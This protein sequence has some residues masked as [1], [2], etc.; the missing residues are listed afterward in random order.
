LSPDAPIKFRA[1]AC[2]ARNLHARRVASDYDEHVK[3][4]I[5][6]LREVDECLLTEDA[7]RF[8]PPEVF[9]AGAFL[10]SWSRNVTDFSDRIVL[11]SKPPEHD[12]SDGRVLEP[13]CCQVLRT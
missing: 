7:R 11:K 13:K 10:P 12:S 8:T 4:A 3:R 2:T 9:V 5:A 1:R 6:I